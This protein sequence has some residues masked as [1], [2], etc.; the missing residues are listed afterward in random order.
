VSVQ[1]LSFRQKFELVYVVT[2]RTAKVFVRF[3][4]NVVTN[5]TAMLVSIATFFFISQLMD[6]ANYSGYGSG[7]VFAFMLIGMAFNFYATITIG[8]YLKTVRATYWQNWMEMI[9]SAPMRLYE[10]FISVMTWSYFY[11]TI[12]IALYFIFGI[13]LFGAD[14]TIPSAWWLVILILLLSILAM[15]GIGLISASMFSL[16]NARK[17]MEPVSYAVGLLA[18]LVTGVYFPVAFLPDWFEPVAYALPHTYALEGLRQVIMNNAGLENPQV[19]LSLIA[20]SFFAV[21]ILPLGMLLF[22]VGLKKSERDGTL[23]RWN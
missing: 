18:G 10:F 12:N 14:I 5:I 9:I 2:W 3:K 1:R 17:G 4:T 6:P 7:D 20:L 19:Q 22:N 21:T 13:F 16:A 15:S 23:A 11:A 8:D